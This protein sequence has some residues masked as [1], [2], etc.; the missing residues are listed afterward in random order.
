MQIKNYNYSENNISMV[1]VDPNG[2]VWMGFQRDASEKCAL[3]KV[4]AN[5][6]LQKYYDIDIAILE[7]KK[8]Y[9]FSDYIYLAFSDSSLIGRRYS[10][11]NPLTTY[12]DFSLPL[13]IIEAPIDVLAYGS[14]VYFLIPGDISGTNSKICV[15]TLNGTFSEIIDLSTVTNAKSFTVSSVTGDLWI[16]TNKPNAE[17]IRVN[18]IS[19]GSWIYTIN[20]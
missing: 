3:Q 15:F 7:I 14:Y 6:P 9:I 4:S 19:G 16:V 5:N 10:L 1:V 17:Y 20:T 2:Y 11:L 8:G 12:T 18:Q 13:G